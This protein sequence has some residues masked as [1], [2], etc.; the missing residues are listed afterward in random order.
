VSTFWALVGRP[1]ALVDGTKYLLAIEKVHPHEEVWYL[2][3]LVVDPSVQRL[4]IGALVQRP[5]LAKADEDGLA[6]YLETQNPDNLP[7]YRRF[8]YEVVEELRPVKHGPPLWT[9]RREPRDPE[10]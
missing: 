10:G 4:G 3:L 9:M 5:G 7:Y 1:K 8:G 2:Q 6:C